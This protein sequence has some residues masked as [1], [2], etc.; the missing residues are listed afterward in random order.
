[1]RVLA[2]IARRVSESDDLEGIL[3]PVLRDVG[4]GTGRGE[5]LNP[6]NG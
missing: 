2:R 3:G 1:M 6:L 5:H 4:E